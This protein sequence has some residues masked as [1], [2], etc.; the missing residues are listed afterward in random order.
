M[1]AGVELRTERLLLR[2][3]AD[4]D[5]PHL[6]RLAGA[7]EVAAPTL[8]IPHPYTDADARDFLAWAEEEC[9]GGRAAIF[10]ICEGG[11]QPLLGSIGLRIEPQHAR[12]ELGFW[13]GVPYW[14]R[15]YCTEAGQAVL[16]YAFGPL[17]LHRVHA[18]VLKQNLPSRRV[19]QKLGMRYEGCAR[20]H[21]R[22]GEEFL[23][24][25]QYGVT[26]LDRGQHS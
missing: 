19:L 2:S 1:T 16:A 23:D 10:A 11:G 13:L 14:G 4:A 17:Q 12:A 3:L 5:L 22:E 21:V 20:R 24:L 18:S 15:G 7:R 9:R 8:L 26:A 25:E 6:A